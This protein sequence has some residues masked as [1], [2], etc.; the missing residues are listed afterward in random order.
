MVSNIPF[1]SY[2]PEWKDYLKTYS[3]IF[4]WKSDLTIY[5]PSG[6]SEILFQMVSTPGEDNKKYRKIPKI[7]SGAYFFQTPF[8]RGLLLEAHIFGGAYLQREICVSELYSWK[9][10]YRFCFVLLCIWGQFPSTSHRGAYIWRGGST[11]SFFCVTGL[12]GLY[13]EGLIFGILRQ[14]VG[15]S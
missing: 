13:L 3:S 8:L 9:E 10:I 4:G 15:T 1:G 5:L 2:Q 6:I 11:E 7:S 14:L 12:G